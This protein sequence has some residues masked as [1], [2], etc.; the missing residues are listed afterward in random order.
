METNYKCP[1]CGETLDYINFRESGSCQYTHWG[2][3]RTGDDYN[4]EDAEIEDA[5][6]DDHQ[7]SEI[8]YI[9]PECQAEVDLSDFEKIEKITD[10]EHKKYNNIIKK[11]IL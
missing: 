6:H 7:Y 9:C 11:T 5:E 10:N 1:E 4:I 3:Y 8:D 2:F